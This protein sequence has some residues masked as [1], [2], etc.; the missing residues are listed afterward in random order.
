MTTKP[1][2]ALILLLGVTACAS[3]GPPPSPEAQ[4]H[5]EG[6]IAEAVFRYQFEHNASTLRQGAERYCL[7][8][9]DERNPDAAFLQRFEAVRPPVV[10]AGQ[11]A[12]KASGDLFFRVQKLEWQRDDEIWVR[13]GYSEG[14]VSAITETYLVHRKD[15]RW[16]VDGSRRETVR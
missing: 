1:L 15:G 11:C 9:P 16:T 5:A 6:D 2:A 8:L 13:G 10:A 14:A 7:S 12:K 3:S 4:A